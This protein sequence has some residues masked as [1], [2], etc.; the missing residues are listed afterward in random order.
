MKLSSINREKIAENGHIQ[1]SIAS[2]S[3]QHDTSG[4]S[5]VELPLRER[6]ASGSPTKLESAKEAASQFCLCQ[7]DPKIPR[8]RNGELYPLV[9][10]PILGIC[11]EVDS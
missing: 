8:P 2:P 11:A 6:S 10:R 5:T 7:P 4:G 1:P 9:E 3:R